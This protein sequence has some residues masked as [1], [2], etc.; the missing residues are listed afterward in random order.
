MA[1]HTLASHRAGQVYEPRR[2]AKPT[3]H[4]IA[5][6]TAFGSAKLVGFGHDDMGEQRTRACKFDHPSVSVVGRPA[7][8]EHEE[9]RR[10]MLPTG[11][12]SLDHGGETVRS[13]RVS[14]TREVDPTQLGMLGRVAQLDKEEVQQAGPARRAAHAC[15]TAFAGQCIEQRRLADV[16]TTEHRDLGNISMW[17]ARDISRALLEPSSYDAPSDVR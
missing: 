3:R 6:Q 15:Q 14:I 12:I 1:G 4:T 2:D 13:G 7:S 9:H 16:R 11:E 5:Q 17:T 8:I 10:E